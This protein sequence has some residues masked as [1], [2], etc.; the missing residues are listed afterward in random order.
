MAH[1]GNAALD[2]ERHG[3]GHPRAALE[4][5]G[6]AMG[7]FEDA[8][9]GMKR[10]LLRGFIGAERH[11][12][13]DQ[14]ALR[15]AHHG[16]ALQDHHLQRHRHRGLETVHHIAEGIAD[17]DDV[18]I[19]VDQCSG[20]GVIRSQHHDWLAVLAGADIRRGL[21]LDGGLN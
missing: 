19:A 10:L 6:A 14:R 5:D 12:D 9:R 21:A 17:Q 13:H 18:A 2:Q 20:M 11:I 3:L 8:H 7:F 15:A 1:H 16:V 4:F